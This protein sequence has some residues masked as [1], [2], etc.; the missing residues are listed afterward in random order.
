MILTDAFQFRIFYD[1]MET[2]G[3][4]VLEGLVVAGSLMGQHSASICSFSAYPGK[5]TKTLVS[6]QWE[7][8][9]R[10]DYLCLYCVAKGVF[11]TGTGAPG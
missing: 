3:S 2:P 11:Q 10:L 5:K 7:R 8:M 6:Q 4:M 9:K 1:N